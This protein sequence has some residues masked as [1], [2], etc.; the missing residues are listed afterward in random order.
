[1][2]E[3]VTSENFLADFRVRMQENNKNLLLGAV[4][5]WIQ[6]FEKAMRGGSPIQANY[7]NT[8]KD[9]FVQRHIPYW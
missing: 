6:A 5:D 3:K 8:V 9:W 1:V 2:F 4:K 7:S